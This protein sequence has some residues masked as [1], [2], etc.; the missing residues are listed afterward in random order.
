MSYCIRFAKIKKLPLF[1]NLDLCVLYFLLSIKD[2]L[3]NAIFLYLC[4]TFF[5]IK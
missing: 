5:V 2:V 4:K 1:D 3:Y